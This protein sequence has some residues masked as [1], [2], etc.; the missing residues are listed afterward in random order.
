MNAP[1]NGADAGHAAGAAE[2]H[3]APGQTRLRQLADEQAALRRV[4]TLV[5][6]GASA[7]ELFAAVP[8]EAGQLLQAGQTTMI[9]YGSDDTSTVVASW[10]I[11]GEPV[12]PI[13]DRQRLGGKNLTTII[14]QTR[15]P[16]RIDSSPAASPTP[17]FSAPHARSP[18]PPPP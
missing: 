3:D 11:S 16:A 8:Q 17:P 10:R 18:P 9:R 14:S 12:P 1:D 5:A 7:D 2:G 4:A 6:R 13:G 15:R